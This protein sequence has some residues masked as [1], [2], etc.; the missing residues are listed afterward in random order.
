M[1]H[2]EWLRS[3]NPGPMLEHVVSMGS[4][5]KH[6]LFACAC[7]RRV[8]P[9]LNREVARIGVET[10]ERYAD[11][12]ASQDELRAVSQQNKS[13][14]RAH[15]ERY[16]RLLT[17]PDARA[18]A[19]QAFASSQEGFAVHGAAEAGRDSCYPPVSDYTVALAVPD[20]LGW[21]AGGDTDTAGEREYYVRAERRV[22][23]E[24]LR[25]IFGDPFRRVAL[26]AEWRTP[27]VL[28]LGRVIY[29]ERAFDLMP[30]LADALQ[31][32][33]CH[34]A[35]VLGHCRGPGPHVRGCW[36]VDLVLGME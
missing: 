35:D 15:Y 17:D 29:D 32:G 21:P 22:H 31:D 23:A 27:D 16:E 34:Y 26:R 13:Y 14:G 1:N 33:G 24:F 2:A 11:G 6:R 28:A 10:I 3:A 5:R 36:V 19:E 18:E 4:D 25:D 7:C 30:I 20:G 9:R 12:M 8:W